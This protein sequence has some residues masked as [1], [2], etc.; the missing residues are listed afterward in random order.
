MQ[1]KVWLRNF[2]WKRMNLQLGG[3]RAK[4]AALE[5]IGGMNEEL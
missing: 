5:P 1:I 2:Y 4:W 3:W